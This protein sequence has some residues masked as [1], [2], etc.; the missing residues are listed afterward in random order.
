MAF[1]VSP[2]HAYIC[3]SD[4]E[5]ERWITAPI[6]TEYLLFSGKVYFIIRKKV[7]KIS[8][9]FRVFSSLELR[10]VPHAY[11]CNVSSPP[12]NPA[13]QRMRGRCYS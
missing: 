11:V 6:R 8:G 2:L 1:R 4:G 13:R 5:G 3:T 9:K 10:V 12:S 7:L